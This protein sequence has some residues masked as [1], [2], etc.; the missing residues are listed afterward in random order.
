VIVLL[1][2]SS[3]LFLGWSL[4]ANDAANVFGTAV[5]ARMIRFR[6]A[7]VISSLFVI[8]GATLA[9][10]GASGTLGKLA[11]V[12]ELG[13][14]FS[15]ALAAGLS[16]SLMTR[17][18]IPVSTSQA[19]VG[20]LI[21]WNLFAGLETDLHVLQK[22]VL[23][24]VLCPVL[25]AAI[26]ALLYLAVR[27]VIRRVRIHILRLDVST[28]VALLAAGAF[29]SFSLGANNIANVMGVFVEAVPFSEFVWNGFRIT[30]AQQLFFIGALAISAGIITYSRRVMSTVGKDLF[31]LSPV[32]AFVAVFSHSAVLFLFASVWLRDRL[33]GWGLP[34]LPLV[35]VSSSQAIVGAVLGIGLVKTGGRNIRYSILG[36]IALGWV[37]T[38][39]IAGLFSFV[40][41][42]LAR[43]LTSGL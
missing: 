36:K 12:T 22:I 18:G 8:L 7:A 34:A 15:V 13:A 17:T 25:A 28:R 20:A 10:A 33:L 11:S 14:A 21:G 32:S 5:E 39:V 4:G 30:A 42:F 3:G 38:P 24:W 1:Y 27:F 40:F 6:T 23:S 41:L 9:G 31:K 26:S 29:G 2:L 43:T 19:I 37:I 35:P 16:V